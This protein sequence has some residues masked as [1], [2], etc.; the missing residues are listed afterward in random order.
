MSSADPQLSLD[1][2][3]ALIVRWFEEVWNPGRRETIREL[4]APD[5]VKPLR[6]TGTSIARIANGPFVEAWQNW[7][8]DGLKAQLP[9]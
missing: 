1:Q 9:T 5:G 2:K 6:F 8:L 4:F 7:D 3:K